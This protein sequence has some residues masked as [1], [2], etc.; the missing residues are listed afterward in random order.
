MRA[1]KIYSTLV[2]SQCSIRPATEY[3][4]MG[5]LLREPATEVE[6]GSEMWLTYKSPVRSSKLHYQP[7]RE[8]QG[9][10]MFHHTLPECSQASLL[11]PACPRLHTTSMFSYLPTLCTGCSSEKEQDTQGSGPG[12]Q[13]TKITNSSLAWTIE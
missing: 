2:C 5:F 9:P 1:D 4:L 10:S 6:S 11:N 7:W 13:V 3:Y 8:G 12:G